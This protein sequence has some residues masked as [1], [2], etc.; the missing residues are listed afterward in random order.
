MASGRISHSFNVNEGELESL[1]KALGRMSQ[2]FSMKMNWDPVVNDAY[3]FDKVF[4]SGGRRRFFKRFSAIFGLRALARETQFFS[5]LDDEELFVVDG[6]CR[7][8]FRLHKKLGP[9]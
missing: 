2:I 6:S 7:G 9:C 5:A 4:T 3:T 8:A 1:S